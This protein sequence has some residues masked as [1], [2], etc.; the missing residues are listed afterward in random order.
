MAPPGATH[1]EVIPA[2]SGE[3]EVFTA[4]AFI[5]NYPERC[6]DESCDFDDIGDTAAKGGVFQVDGRIADGASLR[7]GGAV[8]LGQPAA[9]GSTLENPTGAEVHVAIAPHGRA[10]T[11]A[12]LWAQL[13][14]PLG[15]PTL[16]WVATF[17]SG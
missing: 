6:T 2:G 10:H 16:W 4:W 12:D 13:N 15:N 5:F 14:G 1:P 9:N 17:V 11:D 3:S 7:L 8:R